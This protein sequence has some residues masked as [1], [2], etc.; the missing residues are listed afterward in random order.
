MNIKTNKILIF[1]LF[2]L[3]SSLISAFIIEFGF[4]HKACKLCIYQR[5]PYVVSILL[6][7]SILIIKKGIKIHLLLLSVVFF[8]GSILAFYHFGIEQGFFVEA[9]VCET[10]NLSKGLTKKDILKQLQLNTVSCKEV[11]FRFLGLSLAS[12]NTI[13]SLVLCYIFFKLYRNYEINK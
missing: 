8:I 6:I 10:Q 3:S 12:I 9:A 4:G 7:F 11:S 5:Y 13:L 1:I 2:I